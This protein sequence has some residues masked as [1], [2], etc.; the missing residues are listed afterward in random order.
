[1]LFCNRCKKA[2]ENVFFFSILI[3]FAGNFDFVCWSFRL[4]VIIVIHFRFRLLV[5][6]ISFA[7]NHSHSF[8]TSPLCLFWFKSFLAFVYLSNAY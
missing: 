4:L 6:L 7:G 8:S 5:I 1:M 2:W 3:S